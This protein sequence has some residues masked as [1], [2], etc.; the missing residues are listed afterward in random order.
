MDRLSKQEQEIFS[1]GVDET[2]KAYL[3]ETARWTKFIAIFLLIVSGL[4]IL[5]GLGVAVML[6]NS[7]DSSNPMLAALGGVGL[8]VIYIFFFGLYIYPTWALYKF[9]KLT[10][11]SMNT[12]NQQ[13]FNE[14]LRYQKNMYKYTGILLIIVLALYGISFIFGVIAVIMAG[15]A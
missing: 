13:Q 10:N 8:A 5:L 15:G 4:M 14:A 6:G 7:N 11:A 2:A 9:S 1:I 3:L 12:A